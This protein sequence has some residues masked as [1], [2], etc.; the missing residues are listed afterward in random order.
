MKI[1]GPPT[2]YCRTSVV[3]LGV[4]VATLGLALPARGQALSDRYGIVNDN[5]VTSQ[6]AVQRMSDGGFGW[7]R[8]NLNWNL[9]NP[10]QGVYDWSYP[11]REIGFAKAAGL[12]IY[13]TVTTPPTWATGASYPNEDAILYCFFNPGH[14]DCQPGPN[15]KIP[16]KAAFE[17]FA[18]ELVTRYR[19]DVDAWGFGAEVHDAAFWTGT[20][21]QFVERILVP[22]Y[23]IVKQIAG[24]IVAG[25]DEDVTDS[26]D[27]LLQLEATYGRFCDVITFHILRQSTPDLPGRL[28]D[29]NA[30]VTA[31]GQGRPVWLTE[32]G[33]PAQET[34]CL[35]EGIQ[36]D[37]LRV[38]IQ[39]ID[40]RPWITRIFIYRIANGDPT[41]VGFG[42]LNTVG[43]SR[44]A[45]HVMRNIITGGQPTS[46]LAEGAAGGFFDLD[47]AVANPTCATAT[48]KVTFLLESARPSNGR[49][50]CPRERAPRF[51]S[52]TS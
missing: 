26:L 14:P 37:W 4:L 20:P 31:R 24:T 50:A 5:I 39:E 34:D 29:L 33:M 3:S 43:T 1:Q 13:L 47:I 40:A 21:A 30:V 2:R 32:L 48:A 36:A 6:A 22:G 44:T 25:P 9:V 46:Y 38:A 12:K 51:G 17:A 11:D 7:I 16:S 23:N 42:L 10:A 18:T 41:A 49:S 15:A 35:L 19:N 8:Y 45:W 27:T 52:T 28:D